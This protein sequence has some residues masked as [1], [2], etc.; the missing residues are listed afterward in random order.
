MRAIELDD[1]RKKALIDAKIPRLLR[2]IFNQFAGMEGIA[3]IN[4]M[5]RRGDLQYLRFV[6]Q[7][8]YA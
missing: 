1:A 5:L 7:K 4:E 6:L 8:Q 3:P 2:P